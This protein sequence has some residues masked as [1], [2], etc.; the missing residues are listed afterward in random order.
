MEPITAL[1]LAANIT[2]FV[3]LGIQV[4]KRIKDFNSR[5][6]ELPDALQD[7]A[8]QLDLLT[9]VL[10]RMEKELQQAATNSRETLDRINEVVSKAWRRV[11]R[12][13]DILKHT[14][15]NPG[16]SSWEKGK[17]AILS[18]DKE[19]EI[20]EIAK[21][22]DRYIN[23]LT[24]NQAVPMVHVV[25]TSTPV[26]RAIYDVPLRRVS[27][28]VG[29]EDQFDAINAAF[30]NQ[31][32]QPKVAILH[33]M[34]GQ[35]KTQI[36]LEYCRR[37]KQTDAFAAVLWANASSE[38]ALR[39]SYE[40][41]S[42]HL[43]APD[44]VLLDTT[45]SVSLVKSALVQRVQPYLMVFDNYDDPEAFPN[46]TDYLPAGSQGQVLFTSRASEMH[47]LGRL[48]EVS[49]MAIDDSVTLLLGVAGLDRSEANI[50]HARAVTRR[51][52]QLPLA[53]DQAGSFIRQRQGLL[54]LREFLDYY[55]QQTRKIL[56]TTPGPGVWQYLEQ[57]T[58]DQRERS[59]SVFTTW[60]M[61]L[62]SI[63]PETEVGARKSAFL[64]L[65]GFFS[66]VDVSEELFKVYH[67]KLTTDTEK[68]K[69]WPLFADRD[70]RWSTSA[71]EDIM[72][73]LKTQSLITSVAR[74]TDNFLHLSLHPLVQDWICL[75]RTD[76]A[77]AEE[78][79]LAS[80][81]LAICMMEYY[82]NSKICPQGFRLPRSK[83]NDFVFHLASWELNSTRFL[84]ENRQPHRLHPP[85][86]GIDC[87]ELC[88]AYFF[89][90]SNMTYQSSVLCEWLA[91]RARREDDH[92]D[93]FRFCAMK[94]HLYHLELL[95]SYHA[96][97][98][99]LKELISRC[100]DSRC[101]VTKRE[102]R[103]CMFRLALVRYLQSHWREAES[104]LRQLLLEPSETST[105]EQSNVFLL[106]AHVLLYGSRNGPSKVDEAKNLLKAAVKTG[107]KTASIQ[108]GSADWE[109]YDWNIAIRNHPDPSVREALYEELLQNVQTELGGDH[110]I[111]EHLKQIRAD[112]Y[113][114]NRQYEKAETILR[115]CIR[116]VKNTSEQAELA[117]CSFALG[118]NLKDQGR[119]SE[120]VA[121]Y[122]EAYT[123]W[124][125]SGYSL[126][127]GACN[128]IFEAAKTAEMQE[129]YL[130]AEE[131]WLKAIEVIRRGRD[132]L[133]LALT[134]KLRLA[135]AKC[136]ISTPQKLRE[137]KELLEDVL[138]QFEVT[139]YELSSSICAG[140]SDASER[141]P[142]SDPRVNKN[143]YFMFD[144]LLLLATTTVRLGAFDTVG[145]LVQGA[146][147]AFD[148]LLVKDQDAIENYT[149]GLAA[150][151]SFLLQ[152]KEKQDIDH[153]L[154]L[155]TLGRDRIQEHDNEYLEW[156]DDN[157]ERLRQ[158][159]A[160]GTNELSPLPQVEPPKD[161][162]QLSA[163]KERRR[164]RLS[165]S[166]LMARLRLS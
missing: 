39:K 62:Q 16:D 112:L 84:N 163:P 100:R 89:Y 103:L 96:M 60:E 114:I 58:D 71:F 54:P 15:P 86:D 78:T 10:Q 154:D 120:A 2:Q 45:A 32:V 166:R 26:N 129:D 7:V 153:A 108:H 34:G 116:D 150:F 140:T 46:V 63:K 55:E 119:D 70:G 51:L 72:L 40:R 98:E 118:L 43:R 56:S 107:H 145:Q 37:T 8:V 156:L 74:K 121:C 148:R 42:E 61:C 115:Q 25:D 126:W 90:D 161:E 162:E 141:I 146:A 20:E 151:S 35:G 31:D 47:R 91:A 139:P 28:F 23:L 77:V 80:N 83:R 149:G 117:R 4:A 85:N 104:L 57:T 9:D 49:A 93:K 48:I 165:P 12:M 110:F 105:R 88:F 44:Q 33:G 101:Q 95:G 87:V 22:L 19:S 53:I 21:S 69:W 147:A 164:S 81:I 68:P 131:L 160:V 134:V 127:D 6:I 138:T 159:K 128:S 158:H 67:Q 73:E 65:L 3:V 125:R 109:I 76:A 133:D 13:D 111:M 75:R 99:N 137:A 144:V 66:N 142:A 52:G 14:L 124:N 143:G 92:Y 97:E 122:K 157:I 5:Q 123:I 64:S 132:E 136:Y 130:F 38:T 50:R 29:R 24:L 106:L 102:Y 82:A 30:D 135:Q 59:K 41:I 155:I 36:A 94:L 79:L 1:G 113:R 18:I 152:L 11:N 17:K 27:T